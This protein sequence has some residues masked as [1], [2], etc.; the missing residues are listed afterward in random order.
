[1]SHDRPDLPRPAAPE[2]VRH[3]LSEKPVRRRAPWRHLL[4]EVEDRLKVLRVH[5]VRDATGR[6]R[7]APSG[8]TCKDHQMSLPADHRLVT[9]TPD[10]LREVLDLDAWSFPVAAGLD[11]LEA[12]PFPLTWDRTVGV[13][14]EIPDESL[15]PVDGAVPRRRELVALHSAYPYGRFPVPGGQ[16]AAAGLTWVGV[17][18]AHRRRGL[19]RSMMEHHFDACSAADEPV[20]ALY[21]ADPAIYARF[22][23]AAAAREVHL[24]IPRAARLHDVPGAERHT[25]RVERADATRHAKLVA[26]VHRRAGEALGRPGWVGRVTPEM[27]ATFWAD[28]VFARDGAEDL[29]IVVVELE[30]EPRGYALLRREFT[31]PGTGPDGTVAVRE[32]AAV[33]LAAARALWGTLT[34]MDLMERVRTPRLATDDWITRLLVNPRRCDPHVVDNLWV[35][36]VNVPGALSARQY[37]A[38]LDV[39]LAVTDPLVPANTGHWRLRATAFGPATCQPTDAPADVSVDV[40]DLGAAYLGS[41][42]LASTGATEHVPGAL[43]RAAAAFRWHVEAFCSW[44][45]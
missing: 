1:M 23:Y 30:G 35:R 17:H 6:H 37:A 20:S 27:T 33:D 22:G 21:A 7:V 14:A 43:A 36:L 25:L 41:A 44:L 38:D 16:V 24:T 5:H 11:D 29:R 28:P 9:L 42:S 10:R 45:W 8:P 34:T 3:R 2:G 18:P 4:D 39:V 19:L 13:D 12:Q 32:I 26:D 15:P 31:W 40:A